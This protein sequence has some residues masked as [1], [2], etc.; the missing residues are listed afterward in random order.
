M[1][2]LFERVSEATGVNADTLRGMWWVESRSGHPEMLVS[3]TYAKGDWQFTKETMANVMLRYGPDIAD[4]LEESG[5]LAEAQNVRMYTRAFRNLAIERDGINTLGNALDSS[6]SNEFFRT[7]TLGWT[8]DIVPASRGMF[9]EYE[10]FEK[11]DQGGAIIVGNNYFEPPEDFL[12]RFDNTR[13]DLAA[14]TTFTA[15]YLLKEIAEDAGVDA[16]DYGNAGALYAGYNIGPSNA[17]RLA[18]DLNSRRDAMYEIGSAAMNN[19]SF[20][21]GGATGAQA[22]ANYQAAVDGWRNFDLYELEP[23]QSIVDSIAISLK[24]EGLD[25]SINPYD[26][27]YNVL[28]DRG[29]VQRAELLEAARTETFTMRPLHAIDGIHYRLPAITLDDDLLN[30]SVQALIDGIP[31]D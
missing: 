3:P 25:P 30:F 5:F 28:E 11:Y 24:E 17:G 2:S 20:F 26:V 14:T 23:T 27:Y 8:Q 4:N 15:G 31:Q 19:P 16:S 6:D 13:L 9:T 10:G 21:R 18:G 1:L 12:E 29:Y 7:T 22:L